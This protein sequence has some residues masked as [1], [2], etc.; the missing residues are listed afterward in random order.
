MTERERIRQ[1]DRNIVN[2]LKPERN[3]ILKMISSVS[4]KGCCWWSNINFL[5]VVPLV[6]TF[7]LTTFYG[8]YFII[9]TQLHSLQYPTLLHLTQSC[10]DS[11]ITNVPVHGFDGLALL[12]RMG[13]LIPVPLITSTCAKK[14]KIV[15]HYSHS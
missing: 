1:S 9:L 6:E 11:D 12:S 7:F 8:L 5:F 13:S 10:M 2:Y 14:L 15:A 3:V 4:L